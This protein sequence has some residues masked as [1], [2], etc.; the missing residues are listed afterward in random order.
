MHCKIRRYI[1]HGAR[2]VW[3][4]YRHAIR[5]R[6]PRRSRHRNHGTLTTDLFPGLSINLAEIFAA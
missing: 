2:E 1:E 3:E 5:D 4:F 6:P